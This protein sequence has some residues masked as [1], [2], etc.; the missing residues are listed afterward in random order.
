MLSALA[1]P[2]GTGLSTAE[3]RG[4]Q[5][6]PHVGR[7]TRLVLALYTSYAALGVLG[8]RL[9]GMGWFDAVNHSLAAVSTGGFSTRPESIG[10]WDSPGVEAVTIL[11]MILGTMNF[12][13]AYAIVRGRL[14]AWRR[15][16]ETRVLGLLLAAACVMLATGV[17]L[18]R[19]PSVGKA[20][21]VAV[22]EA[23]TAVSTTGYST[24]GYADWPDIGWIVLIALMIVGGGTGSTAGG[25]KQYRLGVLA[26]AIRRRIRAGLAPRAAIV[27]EQVWVGDRRRFLD[28]RDYVEAATYSS[29]YLVALVLGTAVL[30]AH[31][32]PMRESVFEYA[33]ALGTVG[34]SV[35]IT[36]PGAPTGVLWAEI[37]GMFVGRLE[38]FAI[39]VGV[40]KLIGDIRAWVELRR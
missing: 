24:V 20:L 37:V 21:R 6:V 4:E 35:G 5:L 10:Y 31:G 22:F 13:T 8:L 3:G 7:S 33:S 11:L 39:A 19:F 28:D 25:V 34:L 18:A 17:T 2:A 32:Y 15:N 23:V 1:G 38:F 30:T 9:A 16:V 27:E 12:L 36:G 26:H 29:L 40:L 14:W